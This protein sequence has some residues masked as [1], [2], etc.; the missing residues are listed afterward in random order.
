MKQLVISLLLAIVFTSCSYIKPI[1]K[2]SKCFKQ[3]HEELVRIV[4]RMRCDRAFNGCIQNVYY[5]SGDKG[6][7]GLCND[8]HAACLE[9]AKLTPYCGD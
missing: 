9:Y 5:Y 4:Q 1:A 8:L 2:P 7:L 3:S 6:L